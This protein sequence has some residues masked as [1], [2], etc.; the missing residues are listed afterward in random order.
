[1]YVL[2]HGLFDLFHAGQGLPWLTRKNINHEKRDANQCS[3]I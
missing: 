1:M 3:A 2:I